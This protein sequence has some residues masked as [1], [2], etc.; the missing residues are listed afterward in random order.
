MFFL[1]IIYD[2]SKKKVNIESKEFV[3]LLYIYVWILYVC[4]VVLNFIRYRNMIGDFY[5][6]G[7]KKGGGRGLDVFWK[8]KFIK[9]GKNKFVNFLFLVFGIFFFWEKF[10]MCNFLK[11]MYKI[12]L[13]KKNEDLR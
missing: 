12:L 6:C 2:K 13:L 10:W 8:I 1:Y 3:L 11:Y 9:I 5:R 7:F 4:L